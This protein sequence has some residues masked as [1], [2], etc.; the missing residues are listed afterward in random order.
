MRK[1]DIK[2][3]DDWLAHW[4]VNSDLPS[5]M[6]FAGWQMV[7][8]EHPAEGGQAAYRI[9]HKTIR[10]I[11]YPELIVDAVTLRASFRNGPVTWGEPRFTNGM[12]D[13]R[14][15]D[16]SV[17]QWGQLARSSVPPNYL[18]CVDPTI[19]IEAHEETTPPCNYVEILFKLPG[20]VPATHAGKVAAGR[21]GVAPFTA[22]LDLLFGERLLGPM[23]TEEVG[24]VFPDWHWNRLVGGRT[25]SMEAQARLE[26]LDSSQLG[27]AIDEV[28]E[29]A[30]ERDDESRSRVRVA[31]Q[32]YW[33][34]DAD[35]DPVMKFL[36]YW[37]SIEA[38]ELGEKVNIGPVKDRV[39]ALL[40][41]SQTKV[42]EQVG[43]LYGLRSK[44]AHGTL[45]TVPEVELAAVSA[46]AHAI[47][48]HHVLGRV[49]EERRA[50]LRDCL[51]VDV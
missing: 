3:L 41:V 9:V 19:D 1:S 13:R 43:R 14:D 10:T 6:T 44:L 27:S 39:A 8:D 45:R 7:D 46:V 21:A 47:L 50:R 18:V 42:A 33:R 15:G 38:L 48:E 37:L 23:V 32:W 40:S 20:P 24:E 16:Y 22:A 4:Q 26:V 11:V 51:A 49:S 28:L 25:F 30:R 35:S 17:P 36:S 29:R 31:S 5:R 12:K 34:A 2:G